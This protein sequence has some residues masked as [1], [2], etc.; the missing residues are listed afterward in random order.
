ME[1]II[2]CFFFAGKKLNIVDNQQI[3]AAVRQGK[4]GHLIGLY[5]FDKIDR[6]FFAG[7][8]KDTLCLAGGFGMVAERMHQ[9]CFSKSGAA[10]QNKR[11]E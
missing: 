4:I 3:D 5:R 7:N 8:I 2:L 9:M 6:K 10:V 1:K 11:I